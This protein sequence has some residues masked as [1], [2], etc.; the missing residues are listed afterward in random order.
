MRHHGHIIAIMPMCDTNMPY[1]ILYF[2]TLY[3]ITYM[4]IYLCI[5]IYIYTYI[6][7]YIYIYIYKYIYIYT[8]THYSSSSA[9]FIWYFSRRRVCAITTICCHHDGWTFI[10]I[11]WRCVSL[12]SSSYGYG[13]NTGNVSIT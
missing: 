8:C 3:T 1:T 2:T 11:S 4:H 9:F 7:I 12:G 10:C 5:H 13:I 6:Y